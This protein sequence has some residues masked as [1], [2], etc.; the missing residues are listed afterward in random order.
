[1]E[2]YQFDFS[3]ITAVYNVEAFLREAVDSVIKQDFGFEKIQLVLVDDG[4]KD[5]SGRICDDYAEKYPKNVVVIHKENGGASSA[6]NVGLETASGRYVGFLD[7]DDKLDLGSLRAVYHF[8][9]EHEEETDVVAIPLV[10]FDAD[11]GEHMLNYKYE[12]GSRVIDLTTEYT[13]VQT[14]VCAFIR[15]DVVEKIRFNEKLSYSEDTLFIIQALLQKQKIGVAPEAKY[16]YRRRRNNSSAVQKSLVSRQYY[17]PCIK[18]YHEFIIDRSLKEKGYIP[19]FIQYTLAYDMQWRLKRAQIPPE[20]LSTEE[21]AEY[22]DRVYGILSR[23]DD[24]VIMAQRLLRNEYKLFALRMKYGHEP[25]ASVKDGDFTCSF[26]K[27]AVLHYSDTAVSLEFFDLKDGQCTVEGYVTKWPEFDCISVIAEINGKRVAAVPEERRE[28]I[29]VLGGTAAR[30]QGFKFTFPLSEK[31]RSYSIKLF[32][33]IKN[34]CIEM[35]HLYYREF[36]PVGSLY[37][38]AYYRKDGWELSQRDGILSIRRCSPVSKPVKEFH[39]LCE[40]W[41][42]NKQGARKAVAARIAY[43]LLKPLKRKQLWMLSDR[44]M[45]AGDNGEAMFRYLQEHPR[46]NRKVVFIQNSDSPDYKELKKIGPVVGAYSFKRKLMHLLCDLNISSHADRI[47]FHPFLGYHDA[48][49]DILQHVRFI[50]LQHGIMQADL[51][52]WLGRSNRNITGIVTSTEHENRLILQGGYRYTK[53]NVW[54]AGAPRFDLWYHDEK[55]KVTIMPTWR[56][57]LSGRVNEIGMREVAP[58]FE[59]SQYFQFYNGLIN[60]KRLLEAARRYRYQLQFMPHPNVQPV[61]SSFTRNKQVK[62]LGVDAVCGEVYAESD[63]LITDYSSVGFDFAYLRKPVIYSQ[64]DADT[65]FS[66]NHTYSSSSLNFIY[67]RDG[68]GEVEHDLEGTVDRIIEYM[69]NGCQLKEKYRRRIDSFF[70][71]DDRRNCER[72]LKKL[73]EISRQKS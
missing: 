13:M 44:T 22:V 24:D 37:E 17:L 55:R 18:Y 19:K 39:F 21:A 52:G 67:E 50:Y 32:T 40:L 41:K 58:G 64:F 46:K 72:V 1:M 65:F 53:D 66:G 12:N 36:F 31:N 71:F 25:E 27:D 7:A 38:S 48:Y 69:E 20:V 34:T 43:H 28:T 45:K 60:H 6:R 5:G 29:K 56:Q 59:K 26:S 62:F 4:S 42:K 14:N 16:Y 73:E 54:L 51:S 2:N 35:K 30:Y 23:I 33:V 57:N 3:V 68:F 47:Q 10:F 49:R 11:S 61:L 63:L 9:Q 8:F 15:H 70:T